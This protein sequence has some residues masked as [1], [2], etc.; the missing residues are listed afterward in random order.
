MVLA[1]SPWRFVLPPA[2][3]PAPFA[4]GIN[5]GV[6]AFTAMLDTAVAQPHNYLAFLINEE[7]FRKCCNSLAGKLGIANVDA[8]A[9]AAPGADFV[10]QAWQFNL[11]AV[12]DGLNRH[13]HPGRG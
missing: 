4:D 12:G 13:H 10:R 5:Q 6:E 8:D 9:D 2:V 11:A 1:T 3:D 7:H